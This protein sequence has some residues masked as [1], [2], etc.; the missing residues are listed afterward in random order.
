MLME[1]KDNGRP[2]TYTHEQLHSSSAT[3]IKISTPLTIKPQPRQCGGGRPA[4]VPIPPRLQRDGH[5][6]GSRI[7]YLVAC[8]QDRTEVVG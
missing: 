5:R 7:A 8:I 2:A 3:N 1:A 6:R 4:P